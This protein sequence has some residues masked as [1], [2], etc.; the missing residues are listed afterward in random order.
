MAAIISIGSSAVLNFEYESEGGKKG[1]EVKEKEKQ[2][3]VFL[4][5]SSLLFFSGDF[6]SSYKHGIDALTE[7]EITSQCLNLGQMKLKPGQVVTREDLRFSLT[8]RRVKDV[9]KLIDELG[10]ANNEE[11]LE[12]SRRQTWWLRSI[13]D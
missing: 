8:F 2:F 4:P 11:E 12:I 9:A 6:Y 5:S 1:K 10:P 7:D 13:T 3:S